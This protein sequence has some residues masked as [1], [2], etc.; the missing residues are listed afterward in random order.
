MILTDD[1]RLS[2]HIE[3]GFEGGAEL[4]FSSRALDGY[5]IGVVLFRSFIRK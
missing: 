1:A 3:G 5:R 2:V 4:E